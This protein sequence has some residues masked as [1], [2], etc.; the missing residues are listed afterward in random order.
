[1]LKLSFLELE[2]ELDVGFNTLIRPFHIAHLQSLDLRK[3]DQE[4]YPHMQVHYPE[5][6]SFSAIID[7]RVVA[8]FGLIPMHRGVAHSS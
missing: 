6:L 4:I 7:G 3:H 8:C 1:M 5:G 2:E